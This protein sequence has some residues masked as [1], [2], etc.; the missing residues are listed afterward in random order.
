MLWKKKIGNT[1]KLI[2]RLCL[3]EMEWDYYK[4]WRGIICQQ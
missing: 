1:A 2:I 4:V 3:Q